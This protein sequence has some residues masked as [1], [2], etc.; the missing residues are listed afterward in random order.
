M[1][2]FYFLRHGATTWNVEGRI[3]G[4]TDVPLSELGRRQAELL[5]RRLQPVPVEA[6]YTSPLRRA[7]DTALLIGGLVARS[8]LVDARLAELNYGEWEG[9]TFAEIERAAP[10]LYHA[11]EENPADLAPPG[12]ETGVHLVERAAP[13]LAEVARRHACGNVVVVCH[14]TVC[15]LL[16][17]HIMGAPLAEYRRRI[18]MDNAA[19]NIFEAQDGRWRVLTLNDTAHL[20]A[21][22]DY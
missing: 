14:K 21:P 16:A 11:W 13:F 3:C 20:D 15:R 5:A 18:P 8:P 7:L 9:T 10:G 22:C 6:L 12:G 17:C 19:L 1:S 4:S 2:L